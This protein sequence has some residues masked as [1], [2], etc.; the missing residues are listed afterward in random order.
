MAERTDL[1]VIGAGPYA[2][3]A[4]AC[5]R[6]HGIDTQVV[7]RA[8]ELLARADAGRHVPALRARTGTSTPPASTPSRPTSRTAGLDRAD[9]DPMPI[10]VFLDHT[11]WFREQK[12]FD[13]DERLV[14]TLEV[15]GSR[16]TGF[17][18]TMEDG[19]TI[20]AEKVL[21]APGIRHFVDPARPGT[22]VCPSTGGR[23]PATWSTSTPSPAPAWWSSAAG[24]ARTSGRPC[25]ATTARPRSTS[26]TGT[27]PAFERVSWAFVDPYVDQTLGHRGWWR[28][29]GPERAARDRPGVLAGR[30]AH[31]RALAASRG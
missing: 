26:C 8:D 2:Y 9:H 22:R 7:G 10:G 6:D 5:A 4:A 16:A 28:V 30:P 21:A 14:D 1:L 31:P 29:A 12:G 25:S 11:D 3:S 18:A 23:T 19:T 17:V 20:A 13:V 15:D 27:R 24:R